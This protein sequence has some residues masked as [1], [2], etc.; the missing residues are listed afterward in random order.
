MIPRFPLTW[1]E[2]WKRT[3]DRKA[4]RFMTRRNS[5]SGFG[6]AVSK[7]LSVMDGLQRVF[8]ELAAL[9]VRDADVVISTNLVTRLDGYPRSDQREPVDPGVAVYWEEKGGKLRVM[10][11]DLYDRVAD[12]L[13]A[14]AAT[15]DALRAI[16]RH[17][18][19]AILER[20][21]TGFDALP[22][23]KSPFDVLGVSKTSATKESVDAAFRAKA[24]TA[25]PD[26]P[27]GSHNQ[28]S[29]LTWAR[30]EAL[31]IIGSR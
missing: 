4:A 20:A 25:H 7:S 31:K 23:P 18:G 9:G 30:D 22:P 6:V 17:G 12:N 13:A 3:P 14:I 26:A 11:V 21:F 2:G 29:E 19:A 1:P 28:M 8:R 16:E 15:L 27:G 5:V 10:A 24:R